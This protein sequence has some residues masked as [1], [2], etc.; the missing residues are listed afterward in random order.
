MMKTRYPRPLWLIA[1]FYLLIVI[2]GGG[3]VFWAFRFGDEF[4]EPT[5]DG[6]YMLYR[7]AFSLAILTLF[8]LRRRASLCW[9][10]VIEAA[11]N[12][13][14]TGFTIYYALWYIVRSGNEDELQS[15]VS[16]LGAQTGWNSLLCL[17]SL[18]ILGYMIAAWKELMALPEGSAYGAPGAPQPER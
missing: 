16:W 11:S 13:F 4:K 1:I 18:V 8:A 5:N 9:A 14:A 10:I 17:I 3:Q 15:M 7:M 6:F 12:I 2:V